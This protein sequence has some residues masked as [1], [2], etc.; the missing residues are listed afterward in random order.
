MAIVVDSSMSISLVMDDEQVSTADEVLELIVTRGVVVPP[1]WSF[2]VANALLVA[3]RRGRIEFTECDLRLAR[4][5]ALPIS[6]DDDLSL[7]I[8]SKSL[9][10]ARRH[11]LTVS[12]AAYVELAQRREAP[13]ATLDDPMARAAASEGIQVIGAG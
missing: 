10:L 13:L 9:D 1:L 6:F 12:D 11:A 3:A 8:L 5:L 7:H 2:E 4:L